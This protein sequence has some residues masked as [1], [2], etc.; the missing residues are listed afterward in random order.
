MP[1]EGA[2]GKVFAKGALQTT[3]I[4]SD[5]RHVKESDAE[6]ED[7]IDANCESWAVPFF[8]RSLGRPPECVRPGGVLSRDKLL[9]R[10]GDRDSLPKEASRSTPSP[11][12]DASPACAR[13]RSTI[14]TSRPRVACRAVS[15]MPAE[16][17]RGM[18][19]AKGAL[20]MTD[21]G[22]DS[23]HVKES[24]A[25]GEDGIDANCESWA[26]PFFSRSLGR[27]PEC[28]RPGGLLS[29]DKLLPRDND[30]DSL[31]KEASRS[32]PSPQRDASPACAR[33]RSTIATS[34]PRAAASEPV[35]LNKATSRS[36]MYSSIK[37]VDRLRLRNTARTVAI[38]LCSP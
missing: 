25:E 7:G 6:G 28:V 9:P 18:V 4:G 17:A 8:S 29:R 19:F 1:A 20:Q 37:R 12:R 34:R 13:S 11:Q 30:R 15:G 35:A 32:T 5:S 31:P 23:R 3:D 36:D 24:D 33:S 14:A 38:A 26:V 16:G 10:D 27:P 22:S 21:I 2:R